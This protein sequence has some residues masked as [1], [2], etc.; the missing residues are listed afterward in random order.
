MEPKEKEGCIRV[1]SNEVEHKFFSYFVN[2]QPI[3][4]EAHEV[5]DEGLSVSGAD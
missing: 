1:C 5:A 4:E 3:A 2:A